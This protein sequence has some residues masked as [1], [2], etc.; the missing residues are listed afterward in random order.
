M[1]V[2]VR[3]SSRLQRLRGRNSQ[4]V[5]ADTAWDPGGHGYEG[6][7]LGVKVET[8]HS[9]FAQPAAGV[10]RCEAVGEGTA[11]GRRPF[12]RKMLPL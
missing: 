8:S 3:G 5:I 2:A 6:I 9:G 11:W 10:G 7:Q 12:L 1:G 4:E